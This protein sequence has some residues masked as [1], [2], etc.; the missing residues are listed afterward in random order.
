MFGSS[1]SESKSVDNFDSYLKSVIRPTAKLHYT[2]LFIEW[3]IL[4]VNFARALV[5]G[6]RT[7]FNATR[8]VESGFCGK[9]DLEITIST[10]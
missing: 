6:W 2:R 1:V 3:K 10:T 4:D 8:I 9:R 5:D 7:P